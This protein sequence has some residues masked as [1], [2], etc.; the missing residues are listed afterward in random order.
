MKNKVKIAKIVLTIAVIIL[1]ALILIK[2]T[3][4]MIGLST[5]EGQ[6]EFKNKISS[7]GFFRNAY[8]IWTSNIANTFSNTSRRTI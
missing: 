5:K 3:P 1:L 2:L 6:V 4:L 7:M 8:A